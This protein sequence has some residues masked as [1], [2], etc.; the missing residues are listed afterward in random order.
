MLLVAHTECIVVYSDYI[1]FNHARQAVKPLIQKS[2]IILSP[3]FDPDDSQDEER[4]P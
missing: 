2:S 1:H 3:A 4:T